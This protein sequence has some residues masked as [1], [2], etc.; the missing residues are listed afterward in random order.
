M[1]TKIIKAEEIK[2]DEKKEREIMKNEMRVRSR[3]KLDKD[4]ANYEV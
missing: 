3:N 1:K 4:E 2:K